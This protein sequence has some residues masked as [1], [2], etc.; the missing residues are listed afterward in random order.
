MPSIP[1]CAPNLVRDAVILAVAEGQVHVLEALRGSALEEVVNGGVDDYALAG[2]VDGEATN[3]NAVLAGD[4]L[5][6]W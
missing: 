4:V 6:E 1:F 5:D 2:A 3:L